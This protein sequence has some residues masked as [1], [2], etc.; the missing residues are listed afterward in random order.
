MN[1]F[2]E[3]A[4]FLYMIL[5]IG[6]LYAETFFIGDRVTLSSPIWKMIVAGVIIE[7]T[8]TFLVYVG[9]IPLAWLVKGNEDAKFFAKRFL[10][11]YSVPWIILIIRLFASGTVLT[12]IAGVLLLLM[13]VHFVY[14]TYLV[15]DEA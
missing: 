2:K 10:F 8:I 15:L 5:Y 4:A 7:C 1:F 14:G 11:V 12:I 9:S 13:L 3:L 6:I